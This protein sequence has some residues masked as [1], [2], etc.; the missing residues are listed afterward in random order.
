M[1]V[2]AANITNLVILSR[3]LPMSVA[4]FERL[5]A[6]RDPMD[7]IDLIYYMVLHTDILEENEALLQSMRARIASEQSDNESMRTLLATT[8]EF[9][10]SIQTSLL[11]PVPAEA[12][13]P[14]PE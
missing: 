6:S 12:E 8:Q 5:I 13:A 4:E 9:L 11:Q 14:P 7:L 3:E 1:V 10:D 2:R